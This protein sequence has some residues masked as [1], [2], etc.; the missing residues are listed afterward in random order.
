MPCS[1]H[2]LNLLLGDMAKSSVPAKTLFSILQQIYVMFSASTQRWQI[3]KSF[4][5]NLTVK[6]LSETRWECRIDSVNW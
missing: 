2:S 3:L 4:I 1:C 5:E 6:P